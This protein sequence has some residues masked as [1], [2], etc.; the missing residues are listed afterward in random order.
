MNF[1]DLQLGTSSDKSLITGEGSDNVGT[2]S[3]R[4]TMNESYSGSIRFTK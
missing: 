2:F 1:E 4:G 3:I